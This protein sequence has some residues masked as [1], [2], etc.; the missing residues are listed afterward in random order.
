MTY[1]LG[2]GSDMAAFYQRA[3]WLT[4]VRV[5]FVGLQCD[6]FPGL[7]DN[8]ASSYQRAGVPLDM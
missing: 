7:W 8:M 4:R 5:L 6:L 1:S 3:V 2:F